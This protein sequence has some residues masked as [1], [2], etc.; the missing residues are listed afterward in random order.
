M[1][2]LASFCPC[3]QFSASSRPF[4]GLWGPVGFRPRSPSPSITSQPSGG[5][6]R[7]PSEERAKRAR[8]VRR[9]PVGSVETGSPGDESER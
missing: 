1:D 8:S 4:P 5:G 7:T 3:G 2:S 6:P 9:G